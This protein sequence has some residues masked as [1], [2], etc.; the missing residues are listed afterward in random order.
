MKYLIGV[1]LLA[2][3]FPSW[4][5]EDVWY[6]VEEHTYGLGDANSDGSYELTNYKAGAFKLKYESSSQ[7]LQLQGGMWEGDYYFD[8]DFC[9]L[10]TPLFSANH[11]GEFTFKMAEDRFFYTSNA[12]FREV[13]MVTGTC[14]KF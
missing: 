14:T 9:S 3:A 5:E 7:R 10:T 8:C 2:F 13:S 1:L 4:A 6:C 11:K 12:S